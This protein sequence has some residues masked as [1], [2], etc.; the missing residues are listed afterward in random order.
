MRKQLFL[1]QDKK[2]MNTITK[3]V[4]FFGKTIISN[5]IQGHTISI[6][7]LA[8]RL[9]DVAQLYTQKAFTRPLGVGKIYIYLFIY[10]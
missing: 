8:T 10:N 2:P 5:I 4:I 3:M 9:A 7:G 6:D 1:E